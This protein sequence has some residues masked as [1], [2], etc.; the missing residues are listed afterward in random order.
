MAALDLTTYSGLKDAIAK[1]LNRTNLTDVIPAFIALAEAEIARR[2]RRKTITTTITVSGA[3]TALPADCVELRSVHLVTSSKGRDLPLNVGTPEMLAEMR[4]RYGG[5]AGRPILACLMGGKLEVA[6]APDA[7][8]SAEIKY[9][10]KLTPL[11]ATVAANSVL[12]DSPDVYLYGALKHS[13]PFLE[14]D[15]RLSLWTSLFDSAVD[16]LDIAREREETSASL[17]PVRIVPFG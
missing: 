14:H 1:F 13:A 6:P 7:S 11:S 3:T 4:A 9:F 10:E 8:Y 12:T 17:R 5:A 15:E 16:Q 2:V